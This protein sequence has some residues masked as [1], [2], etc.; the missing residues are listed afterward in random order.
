MNKLRQFCRTRPQLVLG[1]LA[2]IYTCLTAL[3]PVFNKPLAT[4]FSL[5]T[6]LDERI[7]FSPTWILPYISWYLFLP[8]VGFLLMFKAQKQCATTLLTMILGM[9]LSFLTYSLFQTT[10]PRPSSLGAD[11]FTRLVRVIYSIDQ[12][13]NAFPS[14]HVLVTYA[15]MLGTAKAQEVKV[16]LKAVIW[17]VGWLI[18]LSTVF[19]KQHVVA[20]IL[21]GLV[22]AQLLYWLLGLFVNNCFPEEQKVSG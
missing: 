11:F 17:A 13:Y 10:V 14:I 1:L 4:T 12:P 16:G 2:A 18:I 9:L 22:L 3:Y 6:P 20:D 21:S 19:V 5:F 7:G 8:G 15:L